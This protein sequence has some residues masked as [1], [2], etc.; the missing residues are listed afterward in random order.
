MSDD[1]ADLVADPKHGMMKDIAEAASAT[2]V[3]ALSNFWSGL[4]TVFTS[5]VATTGIG[6]EGNA[7][8][9]ATD[10]RDS[11][12]YE[13]LLRDESELSPGHNSATSTSDFPALTWYVIPEWIAIYTKYYMA[14]GS[15]CESS[16]TG[17]HS[18]SATRGLTSRY[19]IC[20]PSKWCWL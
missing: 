5:A 12:P 8:E 1:D 10:D 14:M 18:P 11:A 15:R 13:A 3:G 4:Q 6:I 19:L 7:T 16:F 20:T 9:R 17:I 2:M